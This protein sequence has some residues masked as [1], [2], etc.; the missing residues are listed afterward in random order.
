M[1]PPHHTRRGHLASLIVAVALVVGLGYYAYTKMHTVALATTSYKTNAEA[2]NAYVRF[3]MEAYDSIVT[4]YWQ[5]PTDAGMSQLFQQSVQKAVS[6]VGLATASTSL[7]SMDR[8]GTAA[9]LEHVFSAATSSEMKKQLAAGILQVALYN[10]PPNGRDELLSQT[11]QVELR[12]QVSNINPTKDLYSNLGLSSGATVTDVDAAFIQKSKELA[13]STSPDAKIQLA[14]ATYA[15]RVLANTQTKTR[16][17]TSQIEPTVFATTMGHTLYIY[18]S[19]MSP[20][21][22]AEFADSIDNA[23][24]TPG[25]DSMIIDMRGNIGGSLADAA[26]LL[27]Y[28]V[29]SNQY[30]F[31]LYSQTVYNV[32][33]TSAPQNPALLRYRELAVLTDSMTQSTA[34]VLTASLKRFHLARVVGATTRGW[35]TV[36]NTFPLLTTTD[37]STT[38]ALLLV[39]AITLR[40]DQS[41]IQG[42]GVDP[43]VKISDP[44]W[45]SQL[46][47]YFTSPSIIAAL[48]KEAD[49]K[50]IQ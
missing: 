24:S 36:E 2:R 50:P 35:G 34:E 47:T 23:T 21:T 29:G 13:A 41:P 15:H 49:Q 37:A 48:K 31:D 5:T 12:Q 18:I 11:Q 33:R 27:G 30:A 10:L 25:L 38:Y 17:D 4:N 9:M 45:K 8:A 7:P 26:S 32:I 42:R 46:T 40:D 1:L 16:Y 43:D 44:D 6:F 22:L 39:H 14:A 28:F 3:D 20:T 19:K